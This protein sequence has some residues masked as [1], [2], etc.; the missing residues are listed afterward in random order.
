M[1][2]LRRLS[3]VLQVVINIAFFLLL[4]ERFLWREEVISLAK[5]QA[6]IQAHSEWR[7][8]GASFLELHQNPG[9][10]LQ[11]RIGVTEDGYPIHEYPTTRWGWSPSGTYDRVYVRKYND[12]MRSLVDKNRSPPE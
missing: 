2:M 11:K 1:K 9:T 5:L 7:C 4:A 10:V 8:R 6:I 12:Y 3:V